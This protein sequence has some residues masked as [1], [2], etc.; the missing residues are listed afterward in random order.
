MARRITSAYHA[1]TFG[2][3]LDEIVRRITGLDSLGHYFDEILGV[4]VDLDFWIGLPQ[5][6]HGR[7]ATFT[8]GR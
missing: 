5:E 4:P 2:F 8:L 3:L 7:V 6:Q 1:R